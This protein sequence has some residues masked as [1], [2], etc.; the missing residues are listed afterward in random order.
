MSNITKLDNCVPA[1]TS[2]ELEIAS[3]AEEYVN[4]LDKVPCV[5]QHTIHDGI[6][7]RTLFMPKGSITVGVIIKVP[8]T[9]TL[10]GKMAVYIGEEVHH[11][12]GYNVIPTLGKRKQVVYAIEDSYATLSFKTDA[13]TVDEAEQEMTDEYERLLSRDKESV[14]L[15]NI[16]GV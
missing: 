12:D 11:I 13:T 5:T 4:T 1:M 15:V 16:T 14:N 7:S 10:S 2:K 8:T 6:Y 3:E 9:L